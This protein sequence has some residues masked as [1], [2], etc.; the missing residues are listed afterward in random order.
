MLLTQEQLKRIPELYA[1]ETKKDPFVYLIIRCMKAI[2]LITECDQNGEEAFGWC[3]LY[4]DGSCGELG[5]VNL[6]EIEDLKSAYIVTIEEV[7]KRLS[8]IKK[9]LYK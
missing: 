4:G 9:E 5:Y 8:E 2:W 3:D 6:S 7:E 1:Q